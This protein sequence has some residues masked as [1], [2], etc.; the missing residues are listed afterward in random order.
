MEFPEAFIDEVE[1]VPDDLFVYRRVAWDSI[2]GRARCPAGESGSLSGNAFRDYPD[3]KARSLGYPG[4]C[5]SVGLGATLQEHGFGPAKMLEGFAG[6]GLARLRVGELR[7]LQRANGESSPQGIMRAPTPAE[8]WHCV[9]FEPVN[10]PRKRAVANAIADV[11][12]WEIPLV[13]L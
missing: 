7:R 3:A 8:P 12:A 1:A 2:G 11:A 9:V 4:A 13:H 5:M 6:Y 10:S